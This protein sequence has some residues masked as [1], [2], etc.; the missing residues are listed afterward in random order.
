MA[1]RTFDYVLGILHFSATRFLVN[2]IQG[3]A[4]LHFSIVES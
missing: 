3:Q 4:H 2:F 1:I